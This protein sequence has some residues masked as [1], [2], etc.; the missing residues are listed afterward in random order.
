MQLG[1]LR[2]F[3]VDLFLVLL[4]LP[5]D[6]FQSLAL[7]IFLIYKVVPSIF[8]QVMSSQNQ[9]VLTEVLILGFQTLHSYRILLFTVFLVIY[10]LTVFGNL[11][12][13]M[14]VW[15]CKLLHSPMYFFLCNLSL[16][17]I[18]FTTN[19]APNMLHVLL[20][21]RVTMSVTGC[22]IQFYLFG[23]LAAT[24]S[25][26]LTVMSYDRLLAICNP[27][28]YALVMDSR[29]CL[30]L[31][32]S[33]WAGGFLII[34]ITLGFLSRVRFCGLHVI[35]HFFCDFAPILKLS[36]SDTSTV[37]IVVSLLS[38][39]ATL[40][41]FLFITVTYGCI[42]KA[43]LRIP[44]AKG[45]EKVFSTCSS[46]L[47]VVSTYYATMIMVYVVPYNSHSL[48]VN[49]VLSL[50]YTVVT[51]LVN[52]IIYTL[53]NKEIKGALN[54]VSSRKW[55]ALKFHEWWR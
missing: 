33:S 11:L 27:L 13:I 48:L 5:G 8:V 32:L 7:F 24:E 28:H 51:P 54:L 35:D 38:S 46:H 25:F 43:I 41:P 42:I 53:R 36:C 52:P 1:E 39:A 49:K 21:D 37:E 16:S 23:S 10:M 55:A 50:L 17:E 15:S 3:F 14:L 2:G 47:G 40:F 19:I 18:L 4:E 45:K 20:R 30:H 34:S 12:I 29:F 9:T 26:L 31:A 44:S 22:F 6:R